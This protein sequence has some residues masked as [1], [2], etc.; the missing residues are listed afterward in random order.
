MFTRWLEKYGQT[1]TIIFLSLMI[2]LVSLAVTT[3]VNLIFGLEIIAAGL[4]ISAVLPVL[5]APPIL[6]SFLKKIAELA[7]ARDRLKVMATIDSLTGVPNRAH[8]I[9]LAEETLLHAAP[10][11]PVGLAVIDI[12]RFKLINDEFG[13]LAGDDALRKIAQAITA[14]LRSGDVFGRFGGDEFILLAPN[15]SSNEIQD[16][17]NI[18]LEHIQTL[19][20]HYAEARTTLS[21]TIGVTAAVPAAASLNQLIARADRA[22]LQA[23]REGGGK[24]RYA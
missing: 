8:F 20:V 3:L 18:L 17:A 24:T 14:D 22:L 11:Q 12:D 16:I 1:R 19:S 6:Y 10:A 9:H 5:I 23:K 15:T 4:V 21:A 7:E 13:H 2:G